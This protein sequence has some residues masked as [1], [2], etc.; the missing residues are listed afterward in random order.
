VR[1][2]TAD[3][4]ALIALLKQDAT[5]QCRRGRGMQQSRLHFHRR[6]LLP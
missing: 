5:F 1:R 2:E 4:D 3:I 6:Y